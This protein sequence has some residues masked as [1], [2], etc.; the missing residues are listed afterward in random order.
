MNLGKDDFKYLSQEFDRNILN[1]VK[2]KGNYPYESISG[3]SKFSFEKSSTKKSFIVLW[4]VKKLLIKIMKIL[5]KFG[6]HLKWKQ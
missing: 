6:V 4:L 5:L 1:L 2:E 3:F